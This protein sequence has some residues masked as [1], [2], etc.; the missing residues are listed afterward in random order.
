M[1]LMSERVVV[2]AM[3]VLSLITLG[4]QAFVLRPRLWPAGPGVALSGDIV[5]GRHAAPRPIAVIRPPDVS[6]RFAG[7][8]I[9]VSRVVPGSPAERAGFV[10]G[11]RALRITLYEGAFLPDSGEKAEAIEINLDGRPRSAEDVLGEWR[12]VQHLRGDLTAVGADG[13]FRRIY[14]EQPPIWAAEN[15]PWSAWL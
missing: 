12:V 14:L 4:L 7:K 2:G 6:A 3:L 11:D 10:D 13:T 15:R 1:R 5:F 9:T 8:E